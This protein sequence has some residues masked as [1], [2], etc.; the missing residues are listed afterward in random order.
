MRENN[1][2][3]TANHITTG[4]GSPSNWLMDSGASHHVTSD[5]NNLSLHQPYEGPDDI[6]IG[7]GTGLSITHTG[8]STLTSPSTTF[9][10]SNVLCVPTMQQNLISVSQFCN[11][12]K[13]SI[14]FFP[15][16][17]VVKDLTT[18]ATLAHG[19]RRN[20]VYEWPTTLGVAS[21]TK[22]ACV[23]LKASPED[24]HNRLGHLSAKIL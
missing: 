3:P 23:S 16:H 5:L 12:N 10:L 21:V 11:S 22:H 4:V 9:N 2:T 20:N 24:W 15:S 1:N 18:G 19:R 13:T 8:S 17:F 7:D 6:V 14:E